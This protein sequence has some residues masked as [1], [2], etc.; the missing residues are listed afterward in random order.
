MSLRTWLVDRINIFFKI[1]R[2][3]KMITERWL[4]LAT[5]LVVSVSC[6]TYYALTSPDIFQ[7][8]SKI[9]IAPQ[10]VTPTAPSAVILEEVTSYFDRHLNYLN[11]ATVR[12]RVDQ[13]VH[14]F[15]PTNANFKVSATAVKTKGGFLMVV[16]STDLEYARRYS[17][18]WADEFVMF[19]KE[20]DGSTMS[21]KASEIRNEVKDYVKKAEAARAAT[22]LFLRT[23]DIASAKDTGDAAQMRYDK[24]E[25]EYH[26]VKSDRQRLEL[27]KAQDLAVDPN[28]GLGTTPKKEKPD[29]ANPDRESVDPHRSFEGASQYG[30]LRLFQRSKQA[31]RDR[32]AQTL[33][34]DHPYMVK[35]DDDLRKVEQ[36]ISGTL[37]NLDEERLARIKSLKIDEGTFPERIAA[38]KKEVFDSRQIQNE[39]ERLKQEELR[40]QSTLDNL[41][42]QLESLNSTPETDSL[43]IID[44]GQ[45]SSLPVKPDRRKIILIGVFLGMAAGL[46]LIYFLG[47]LDDR[48]ELAE[49]IE[50]ALKQPVLGQIPEM[51]EEDGERILIT[52]L[53]E[54]DMFTEAVRGVRSAVMLGN[55]GQQKAVFLVSSAIPGDG[56]TTFTVNFAATLALAGHRVLLVDA[57]LR[58]GDV[59]NYFKFPR[60]PGFADVLAGKSHW[61]DV[62]RPTD[63]DRLNIVASGDFPPYPGELLIGSLTA[64]IVAEMREAFDFVV[65]DCPP[66][67]AI[68]DAFSLVPLVDGVIFV[69]RSRTTPMRFAATALHS[70]AQRECKI[71]GLVIN[72]M[73]PDTPYYYYKSYY[74]GYYRSEGQGAPKPPGTSRK[75][76]KFASISA[77]AKALADRSGM[78]QA[79][80]I[81][82]RLPAVEGDQRADPAVADKSDHPGA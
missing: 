73:R 8:T 38:A 64:T 7:A 65:F 22:Q 36:E 31:E 68:D 5:C 1:R 57:D 45:G 43:K 66:I 42:K 76:A 13:K 60:G 81:A 41:Y 40:L 12:T 37:A 28:S 67:I 75:K 69:V 71:L 51:K 2:Y 21:S 59:N 58:R 80:P 47:Q 49:E 46:G 29:A 30:Q 35:L 50:E 79:K 48:L 44:P 53:D 54:H 61:R 70:I 19:K 39:H 20:L 52:N 18:V 16:E 6:A 23:N 3:V 26:Q 9:N 14:E 77:E 56:K 78:P 34:P 10:V 72:G 82:G 24:L 62:M 15:Q 11:S 17:R 4:L 33:L 25:S 63:L 74:H 27:Q 32:Y 55:R